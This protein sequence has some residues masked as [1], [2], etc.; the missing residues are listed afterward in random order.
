MKTLI[1]IKKKNFQFGIQFYKHVGVNIGFGIDFE[2]KEFA[3]VLAIPFVTLN[4]AIEF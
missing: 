3:V 2:L 4:F 1:E